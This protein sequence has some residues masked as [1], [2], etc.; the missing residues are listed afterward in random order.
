MD[1]DPATEQIVT[2]ALGALRGTVAPGVRGQEV[3][4]VGVIAHRFGAQGGVG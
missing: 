3:L 1:S 4:E 2:F